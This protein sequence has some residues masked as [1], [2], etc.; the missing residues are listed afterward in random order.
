MLQT[1]RGPDVLRT[2]LNRGALLTAPGVFDGLSAR[3]AEAAGFAALYVSG[4]AIARSMG[5]PDLGLVTFTEMQKR[6]D[7]IRA[8]TTVP[9]IVDADAGY[10]NALNVMRTVRAYARAGAAALHIE[11]QVEPKRCGH[12]DGAQVVSPEAMIEKIAAAVEARGSNGTVLIARTDARAALGLDAAIER[13]QAYAAAGADAIF[14]EA[15]RTEDEIVRIAAEVDAPLLINMFHGG[16]TPLVPRERLAALG[17]RIMIVPSDLQRAAL[18]AMQRA[19][20]ALHRDGHTQSVAGEMASFTER[21]EVVGLSE[22][23]RLTGLLTT[24]H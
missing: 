17:Y 16:K 12:Y 21:D 15:P 6:L 19:A 23:Q 9:L 18:R 8:V 14:V 5:Y 20:A 7:E 3:V 4:G 10:G 13:A 11:D 22:L 24:R 2:L 1:P